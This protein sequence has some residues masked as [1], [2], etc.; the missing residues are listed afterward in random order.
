MV[1]VA[2]ECS[3]ILSQNNI[4][5]EVS[6]RHFFSEVSSSDSDEIIWTEDYKNHSRNELWL[7][8]GCNF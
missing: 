6:F 2:L 4:E 5:A 3:K 8:L 1:K 7:K